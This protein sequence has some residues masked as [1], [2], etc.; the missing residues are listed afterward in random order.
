MHLL[1]IRQTLKDTSVENHIYDNSRIIRQLETLIEI[2][3]D[4]NE[5]DFNYISTLL[6]K[7][8]TLLERAYIILKMSNQEVES[9]NGNKEKQET[10]RRSNK[11]TS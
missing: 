4:L 1:E 3:E 11:G 6:L 8:K 5:A 9:R 10:N 7:S 2:T